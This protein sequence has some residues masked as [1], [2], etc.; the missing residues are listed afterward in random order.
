MAGV[1]KKPYAGH[2]M[3]VPLRTIAAGER[4][5]RSGD[6]RAIVKLR[7]NTPERGRYEGKC[8][9]WQRRALEAA[10]ATAAEAAA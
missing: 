4:R 8:R 9:S 2:S 5:S 10:A 7:G 6:G 1:A 3:L